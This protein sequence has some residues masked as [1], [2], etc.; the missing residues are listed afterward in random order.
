MGHSADS[1]SLNHKRKIIYLNLFNF[2]L[3]RKSLYYVC[4]FASDIFEID[5]SKSVSES[6][7]CYNAKHLLCVLIITCHLILNNTAFILKAKLIISQGKL[8]AYRSS[9]LQYLNNFISGSFYEGFLFFPCK[10][11]K[12][13]ITVIVIFKI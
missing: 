1:Q 11:P 6:R 5:D 4:L 2:E 10:T 9:L 3:H 13:R 12:S 7:V 8:Q